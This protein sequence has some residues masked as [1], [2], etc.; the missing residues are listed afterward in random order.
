MSLAQ[1]THSLIRI[2]HSFSQ[3]LQPLAPLVTRL[4]L[5]HT[6][7]LTGM[8]KWRN[9][10]NTVGFFTD[11]GIPAPA[12]NAAFIATLELVGGVLLM[13]GLGTRVVAALLS[14]T[15]VVA[16]LTADRSD[17]VNAFAWSGAEKGLTDVVP[18][19]FLMFLGWL[20]AFGP[21]PISVDRKLFKLPDLREQRSVTA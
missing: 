2:G 16:L 7:L 20:V 3:S 9:F 13:L 1:R 15:M 19:V 14:S 18:F 17:F 8:G 10:D 11:I 21:G 4:V 12:A 5:G 6:F